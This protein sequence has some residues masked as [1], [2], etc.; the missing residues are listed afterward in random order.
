MFDPFYSCKFAFFLGCSP[1]ETQ[2]WGLLDFLVLFGEGHSH[3][4]P[5]F[6]YP[7]SL[8]TVILTF[9]FEGGWKLKLSKLFGA[10]TFTP[11][12][13]LNPSTPA[14]T[15]FFSQQQTLSSRFLDASL[16]DLC[17]FTPPKTWRTLLIS[18]RVFVNHT[19]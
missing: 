2:N 9:Y 5:P 10:L 1:L 12:S 6:A 18:R 7:L 3:T 13:R 4:A 11:L 19:L 8:I 16:G 15:R 14:A 17:V